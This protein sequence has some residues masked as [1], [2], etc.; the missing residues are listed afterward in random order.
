MDF[1][2]SDHFPVASLSSRANSPQ[3]SC[4]SSTSRNFKGAKMRCTECDLKHGSRGEGPRVIALLIR[5]RMKEVMKTIYHHLLNQSD[6]ALN[7]HTSGGVLTFENLLEGEHGALEQPHHHRVPLVLADRHPQ[8]RPRGRPAQAAKATETAKVA[9]LPPVKAQVQGD[10]LSCSGGHANDCEI[11]LKFSTSTSITTHLVTLHSRASH[12][13]QPCTPHQTSL[14]KIVVTGSCTSKL[15]AN[16]HP[17][18]MS[19]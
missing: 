7:T 10:K 15:L 8:A 16:Q 1:S 14:A 9:H 18:T 6:S 4:E 2:R 13:T 19:L 5:G 11:D 3:R 12:S 17:A